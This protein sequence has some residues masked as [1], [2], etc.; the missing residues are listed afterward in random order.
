MPWEVLVSDTRVK[1]CGLTRPE[2]A[3]AC[4]RLGADFLGVVFA[5]SPRQ[6]SE[7][8]CRE[9]R[10]AVS[11]APLVGV[12][13]DAPREV[14]ARAAIRCDLDLV[15]LHGNENPDYCAELAGELFTDRERPII[16]VLHAGQALARYAACRYFLLDLDKRERD[17]AAGL[18]RHWDA[19]AR[20]VAR[21]DAGGTT[22]PARVF[23]AGALDPGNVRQAITRVAPYAVDVG[24]GVERSPGRKDLA[25]VGR[26]IAEV[27]A[28]KA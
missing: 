18:P 7:T 4:Q 1:I 13:R 19:A 6:V 27:R 3:A 28:C 21:I 17:P 24:R 9:I 11:G 12:F 8:Q 5:E 22:T 23:L 20:V 10:A 15:Q 16:K 2:E 25:A 14:V 26:L